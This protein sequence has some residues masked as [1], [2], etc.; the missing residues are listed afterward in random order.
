MSETVLVTGSTGFIAG[1]L[2]KRLLEEGYTVRGT[3]RDLARED[4]R[5]H[6]VAL[7]GAA[8][9]LTFVQAD[10]M[11][12]E[13]WDE[14]VAGCSGVY[15]TASPF[16]IAEP[17]SEDDLVRP[18]VDGTRRVLEACGRAGVRR[19]VVTSSVAAVTH[20]GGDKTYTEADW[21]DTSEAST[22]KAYPKSKTL[23][24]RAVWE[25]ANELPGL[26]LATI[27]P[28]YVQGPLLSGAPASSNEIVS[29]LLERRDPGVVDLVMGIVDVRDV[30]DAHLA[31]M[32]V[33]EAAGQRFIVHSANMSMPEMAAV[34][35]AEFDPLGY[36][37]PTTRLPYPLIWL[38]GR[39][40]PKIRAIL[41]QIGKSYDLDHSRAESVLG[42]AFRPAADS[43]REMGH[44]MIDK[45]V[46]AKKQ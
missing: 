13:G 33:P 14:A 5:A 11:S 16:P 7:P 22:I 35:A 28:S 9:R 34:L 43:I 6:L 21:S 32:R 19:A 10:L 17:E 8:E 31:A 1:H 39:C 20:G 3:V 27:N 37:V 23:A 24:E 2:I 45:G 29:R 42:I 38:L 18:A 41:P 15:H 4:K 36:N 44:S 40:D 26:E 30:A 25:L 46:V 12:D